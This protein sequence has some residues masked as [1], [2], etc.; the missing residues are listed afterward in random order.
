[1]GLEPN[2]TR[3]QLTDDVGVLWQ[4][5]LVTYEGFLQKFSRTPFPTGDEKAGSQHKVAKNAKG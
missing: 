4:S 1:M 5:H 3:A 2:D